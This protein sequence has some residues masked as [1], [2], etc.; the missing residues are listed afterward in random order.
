MLVNHLK[1]S[2]PLAVMYKSDS[3]G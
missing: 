2:S 3:T 1:P